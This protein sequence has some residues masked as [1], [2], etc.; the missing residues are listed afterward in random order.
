MKE[1]EIKMLKIPY[2]DGF[3]VMNEE[4]CSKLN[5]IGGGQTVCLMDPDRHMTVTVGCR[6]EKLFTAL[7]LGAKDFAKKMEMTVRQMMKQYRFMSRDQE[8][9]SIAGMRAIGFTYEYEAESTGMTGQ[10]FAAKTGRTVYYFNCY[11]RSDLKDENL[12]IWKNMLDG[13][14]V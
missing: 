7:M 9:R 5:L 12:L 2:P 8:E 10:S 14:H 11:S 6:Q 1:F 3:H 13:C 4:E